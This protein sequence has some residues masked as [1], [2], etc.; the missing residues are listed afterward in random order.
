[1]KSGGLST[2]KVAR[3][4]SQKRPLKTQ[5]LKPQL[6][7]T[8]F[9]QKSGLPSAGRWSDPR[10][11]DWPICDASQLPENILV[12]TRKIPMREACM[13]TGEMR[14]QSRQ[15][16]TSNSLRRPAQSGGKVSDEVLAHAV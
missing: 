7:G 12:E 11:D 4:H 10:R 9:S 15:W 1:M 3:D 2:L 8:A 6:L 5:R 13:R 16:E 14:S